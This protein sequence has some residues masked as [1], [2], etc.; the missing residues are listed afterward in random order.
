MVSEE[1]GAKHKKHHRGLKG[2]K[3]S[4]RYLFGRFMLTCLFSI[5]RFVPLSRALS[6]VPL[7]V[8]PAYLYPGGYKRH[9]LANLTRY[10]GSTKSKSELTSMARE[11]GVG[12]TKG[13]IEA[14]YAV[15]D[16]KMELYPRMLIT[17]REHLDQALHR[18]KGAIALSAHF[19]NFAVM[20]GKLL[21]E[22][23]PFRLVLKLPKDPWMARYFAQKME[24]HGLAFIPAGADAFP[25]KDIMRALRKNEVVG[26]I[27]DGDQR[28]G[29]V[30]VNFMGQ[31]LAMPPG[32]AILAQRTGAA[33]LPMFIIRQPDD[34]HQ[35]FI[36]P[37]LEETGREATT[38]LVQKF[39]QKAAQVMESYVRQ[40]PT[41]WYWVNTRHRHDRYHRRV[42]TSP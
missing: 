23:Y 18:G 22:G 13:G 27:V 7:F 11:I 40:Y 4:L 16:R 15:S 42:P 32:A 3:R 35:I 36:E 19:G 31:E 1:L 34:S 14:V 20:G 38:D 28:V 37:P 8:R 5:P 9:A 33:V 17:G 26:L 29:G 30:P 6:L 12:V 2:L 10:Y 41:Q 39:C 21:S 24:R 25:H